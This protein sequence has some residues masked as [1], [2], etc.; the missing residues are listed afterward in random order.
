MF[1]NGFEGVLKDPAEDDDDEPKGDGDDDKPEEE[2]SILMLI[3][4][5][6][7]AG[8]EAFFGGYS[9]NAFTEIVL[10]AC[11]FDD[12]VEKASEFII[13]S[14][15]SVTYLYGCCF[16]YEVFGIFCLTCLCTMIFFG[17][18]QLPA[19]AEQTS[20]WYVPD[21]LMGCIFAATISGFVSFGFMQ[22]FCHTADTLLYAFAYNKKL[23]E[24]DAE[25]FYP[26]KYCPGALRY[27]LQPY[28]LEAH[29]TPLKASGNFS[30]ALMRAYLPIRSRMPVKAAPPLSTSSLGGGSTTGSSGSGR[31]GT[32]R[33]ELSFRS[34]PPRR[35]SWQ[36]NGRENGYAVGPRIDG[37]RPDRNQVPQMTPGSESQRELSLR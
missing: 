9:K 10:Q 2:K 22:I 5:Y 27:L 13:K 18:C 4:T 15:G 30:A 12:A 3:C 20:D 35:G 31:G 8:L 24:F 29:R 23:G 33:R 14:G 11:A 21:P 34:D 32:A 36:G 25:E 1:A 7:A 28:E 6:L 26:G 16:I 37:A 17:C 19:F